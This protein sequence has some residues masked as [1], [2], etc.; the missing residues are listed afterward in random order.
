MPRSSTRASPVAAV[1]RTQPGSVIEHGDREAVRKAKADGR[2]P[3]KPP[4][5]GIDQALLVAPPDLPLPSRHGRAAA[6]WF[7]HHYDGKMNLEEFKNTIAMMR[8]GDVPGRQSVLPPGVAPYELFGVMDSAGSGEIDLAALMQSYWEVEFRGAARDPSPVTSYPR[9]SSVAQPE[10]FRYDDAI[11]NAKQALRDAT[12]AANSA[13]DALVE[14]LLLSRAY[15]ASSQHDLG[16]GFVDTLMLAFVESYVVDENHNFCSM[17]NRKQR[18]LHQYPVVEGEKTAVVAN[19]PLHVR[20]SLECN[21]A[22]ICEMHGKHLE[23]E[24]YYQKYIT[25]VTRGFGAESLAAGDAFNLVACFQLKRSSESGSSGEHLSD[26]LVLARKCLAI[27]EKLLPY[28]S[29]HTLALQSS[30]FTR[31]LAIREALFGLDSLPVADVKYSLGLALCALQQPPSQSALGFLT[32]AQAIRIRELG[33]KHTDSV[34]ATEAVERAK[35]II[36]DLSLKGDGTIATEAEFTKLGGVDRQPIELPV[37]Q[38]PAPDGVGWEV[39]P[40]AAALLAAHEIPL[41]QIDASGSPVWPIDFRSS[42]RPKPALPLVKHDGTPVRVGEAAAM[43]VN[44][45]LVTTLHGPLSSG[46]R[47]SKGILTVAKVRLGANSV[48]V[49]A[50]NA[51]GQLIGYFECTVPVDSV[52]WDLGRHLRR[53]EEYMKHGDEQPTQDEWSL[54]DPTLCSSMWD[55]DAWCSP[56][57]RDLQLARSNPELLDYATAVRD[58]SSTIQL[59]LHC[60]YVNYFCTSSE[61]D[62]VLDDLKLVLEAARQL[63]GKPEAVDHTSGRHLPPIVAPGR[64]VALCILARLSVVFDLVNI[65]GEHISLI[66]Y[67]VQQLRDRRP[68]LLQ[69]EDELDKVLQSRRVHVTDVFDFL[70]RFRSIVGTLSDAFDVIIAVTYSLRYSDE[71][72]GSDPEGSGPEGSDYDEAVPDEEE[73]SGMESSDLDV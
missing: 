62:R 40:A 20:A 17:P 22:E 4:V 9:G 8:P 27:R 68:S 25:T 38:L 73:S 54:D 46:S 60:M 35:R 45:C 3:V 70:G 66:E 52:N 31:P 58:L 13:G 11:V 44:P 33:P 19:L 34:L 69:F 72:D 43:A 12:G 14:L 29:L 56:L 49:D 15:A 47:D 6:E 26:A 30:T 57:G 23:A 65:E 55:T 32:A 64:A 71:Q 61:K 51:K 39:N 48:G 28:P 10:S 50:L 1:P 41:S 16:A 42:G 7:G 24:A 67:L 21:I 36:A 2:I 18:D 53:L 37:I 5:V 59:R 63:R